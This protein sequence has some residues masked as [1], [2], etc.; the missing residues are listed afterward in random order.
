MIDGK[1][2]VKSKKFGKKR[3]NGKQGKSGIISVGKIKRGKNEAEVM[4]NIQ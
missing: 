3:V 2:K 4:L 1:T